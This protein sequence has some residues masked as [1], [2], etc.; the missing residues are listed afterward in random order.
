MA[1][2]FNKLLGEARKSK[3]KGDEDYALRFCGESEVLKWKIGPIRGQA[4]GYNLKDTEDRRARIANTICF[5]RAIFKN[6][7]GLMILLKHRRSSLGETYDCPCGNKTLEKIHS[8]ADG[9]SSMVGY[10]SFQ[11]LAKTPEDV[12]DDVIAF[13]ATIHG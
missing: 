4:A 13:M 2:D 5:S 6:E 8:I 7:D 9:Q 11:D 1:I 10:F 3:G 12:A